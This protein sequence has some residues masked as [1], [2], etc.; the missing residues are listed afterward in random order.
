M[1][2]ARENQLAP[3]IAHG[4]YV[5]VEGLQS[6]HAQAKENILARQRLL[7]EELN[8][9]P[10]LAKAI[11]ELDGIEKFF[12]KAQFPGDSEKK[13]FGTLYFYEL[14]FN[15]I[16]NIWLI[17]QACNH[18]K[19]NEDVYKWFKDQWLYG[20]EFLNYLA[21]KQ[22][23]DTGI[24]EKTKDKQGLATVAIEWFWE[25]HAHYMSNTQRLFQD[26]ITPIQILNIKVDR[27]IGERSAH[28]AERLQASLGL[29]VELMSTIAGAKGLGMPKGDSESEHESSDEEDYLLTLR[30]SL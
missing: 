5:L 26:I 15:D 20:E 27:V 8:N 3:C 25:R 9:N 4:D 21:S 1:Q 14:Y 12:V 13:Y 30:S 22:K 16:D 2:D 24:L 28:R 7:I 18:Q 23:K 17:C 11:M 29:K 10:V 19:S 6:D